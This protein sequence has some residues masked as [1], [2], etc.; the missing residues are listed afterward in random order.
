MKSSGYILKTSPHYRNT[1]V[2]YRKESHIIISRPHYETRKS[3]LPKID[4]L[5]ISIIHAT[6]LIMYI[7][8]YRHNAILILNNGSPHRKYTLL[9]GMKPFCRNRDSPALDDCTN[10]T[11]HLISIVRP[12]TL[13]LK[14]AL[15]CDL[16]IQFHLKSPGPDDWD[17]N[18]FL[19]DLKVNF[20]GRLIW[21]WFF[22]FF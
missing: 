13:E 19:F 16:E 10:F 17:D 11:S 4:T 7:L 14:M 3:T 15:L 21:E 22:Y 2:A 20:T 9:P 5:W 8:F 1:C 6:W 18:N 12:W